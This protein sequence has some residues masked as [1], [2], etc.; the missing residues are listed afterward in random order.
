[1]YDLSGL[2]AGEWTKVL[3]DWRTQIVQKNIL[4]DSC[5]LYHNGK[6]V[7]AVWGI[8]FN[9]GRA[10]TLSECEKLIDSLKNGGNTVMVGVPT[11]WL[12]LDQ[13]ALSDSALHRIIKKSD[14][15]SP[16][17]VGRPKSLA[18]IMTH[19]QTVVVPD[20]QWCEQ[21]N[22]EYLP[23]A[24]PGFSWHNMNWTSPLNL[25]PRLGGEFLWK[26]YYEYIHAG[27]TMIYQAMF[28]EIDEATAIFKCTND[29]P[30]GASTFVTYEGL[31]S[32][33]YLWLVE[34]GTRM[35]RGEITLRS[36][37]P[38]RPNTGV[39]KQ[40]SESPREFKLN[41]NYPNPFNPSTTIR[42]AVSRTSDIDIVIFNVMGQ[43]IA[44][45]VQAKQDAGDYQAFWNGRNEA[46]MQVASGM[47]FCRMQVRSN[48]NGRSD[49]HE[50]MKKLL[51]IR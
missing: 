33:Q 18:D 32:D 49:N 42:Y 20:I 22:K 40:D 19:T 43:K 21:Y 34:E 29:P 30:V 15:V 37:L 47:Y 48:V 28:D 4:Q 51:L 6:P 16:W 23:V 26:Q 3:T 41:Q 44:T 11:H 2:K 38:E 9:D 8:G 7:V 46:G 25:I 13:D 45:I 35:L 24:F 27:S 1:M 36:T 12:T 31:P 5:Y 50:F 17:F 14:I 10:Y 39:N